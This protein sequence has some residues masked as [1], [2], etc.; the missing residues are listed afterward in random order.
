MFQWFNLWKNIFYIFNFVE[1]Q[2]LPQLAI[3]DDSSRGLEGLRTEWVRGGTGESFY[4]ANRKITIEIGF[5]N[6][7][8]L[9]SRKEH[10]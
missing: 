10:T 6:A 5:A 4:I 2:L 3:L 9:S 8:S 1:M 7:K